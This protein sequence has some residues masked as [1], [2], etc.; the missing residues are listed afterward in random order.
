MKLLQISVWVRFAAAKYDAA[1]R[2]RCP[3]CAGFWFTVYTIFTQALAEEAERV[4]SEVS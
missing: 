4:L 2:R 1:Y 3:F